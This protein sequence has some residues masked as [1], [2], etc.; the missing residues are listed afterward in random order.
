MPDDIRVFPVD[1]PAFT[2]GMNG[3]IIPLRD[4]RLLYAFAQAPDGPPGI[5]AC[6]SDDEG[7]TWSSPRVLLPPPDLR[8]TSPDGENLAHPSF[9][10]R[11]NGQL[12]MAYI[13]LVGGTDPYAHSYYRFS[14]DEGETWGEPKVLTPAPERCS[15]VHNS[16]LL[17]L[18]DGRILAP[19][20]IRVDL[21][22]GNDHR[23]FVSAVWHSDDDGYTWR[24]ST[25]VVDMLSQ[26]VEAQE[27]HLVELKDGRVMMLFRTYSG[28][29]GRSY[30]D[31][32]GR[33]WSPGEPIETLPLPTNSS[34]L[35]VSR[36]PSTGDLLLVRS[37]GNGGREP[38]EH[39]RVYNRLDGNKH[40]VRTPLTTMISQDEGASWG[41]ERILAG[42]PYGDYG[43]PSVLHLDE[44]TLVSYHALDGLHVARISP[45]WFYG[46]M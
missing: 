12:M 4:G 5:L 8:F 40:L 41:N 16:K 20:E 29:V 30:S 6:C 9:L 3:D 42:D 10:R 17:R 45:D 22:L 31:D 13:W 44:A 38:G 25:N 28:Y 27:P 36:L 35:N 24:R 7:Q 19:A 23:G 14:A 33:S 34:A 18:S 2:R 37:T 21:E 1:P 11:R 32:R 43:Y 15:M 26:G 39:P 46:D